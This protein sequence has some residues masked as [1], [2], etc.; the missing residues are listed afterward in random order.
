MS[1]ST[2]EIRPQWNP[3]AAVAAWLVPGLGHIVLGQHR[4]GIVL[5]IAIGALWLA[6]LLIGGISVI[7]K[8]ARDEPPQH[9]QDQFDRGDR[10]PGY[11]PGRS[12]WY[13]GQAMIAPS[14][15]I[16]RVRNSMAVNYSAELG[17]PQEP[18]P[19]GRLV[20]PTDPSTPPPPYEPSFGRVAE[21]G[22][23]YTAL[24]GM[25]NLLA[26]IDVLY[27]DPKARRQSVATP[28]QPTN[29]AGTAE[30]RA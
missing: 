3:H 5:G 14:I 6:G 19:R 9:V 13:W 10:V 27:C 22:T 2:V 7:D 15:I 11:T 1:Q 4:R 21:Q 8:Q 12:W 30:V 18:N 20:P 29:I 24:A 26:M 17:A 25:L 23:L 28:I 16:E